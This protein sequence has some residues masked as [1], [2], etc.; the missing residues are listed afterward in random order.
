MHRMTCPDYFSKSTDEAP[1][2][3][4]VNVLEQLMCDLVCGVNLCVSGCCS[5]HAHLKHMR[6]EYSFKARGELRDASD[7]RPLAE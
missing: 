3:S 6:E 4:H 7:V 1:L 5:L 2:T